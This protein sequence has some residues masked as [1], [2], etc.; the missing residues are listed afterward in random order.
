MLFWRHI[1]SKRKYQGASNPQQ[2]EKKATKNSLHLCL[3]VRLGYVCKHSLLSACAVLQKGERWL[4]IKMHVAQKA[5]IA[6]ETW[7]S[8]VSTGIFK[9]GKFFKKKLP[10]HVLQAEFN[11]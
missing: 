1:Q 6:I 2:E 8:L 4:E 10:K 9:R 3:H 11:L 5:K 7:V